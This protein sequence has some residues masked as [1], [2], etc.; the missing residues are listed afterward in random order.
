MIWIGM[1]SVLAAFR[2]DKARDEAGIE[3]PVEERYTD[4][5][6]K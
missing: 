5:L 3:I 6:I 2:I 4:G 1:I